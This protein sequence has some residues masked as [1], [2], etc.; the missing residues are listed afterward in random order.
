MKPLIFSLYYYL[1]A[2]KMMLCLRS[3]F[4]IS[5]VMAKMYTIPEMLHHGIEIGSGF[6]TVWKRM[7]APPTPQFEIVSNLNV[8]ELVAI[9][10][11]HSRCRS[12][13]SPPSLDLI[14]FVARSRRRRRSI[15]LP[16]LLDLAAAVDPRCCLNLVVGGADDSVASFADDFLDSVPGAFTVLRVEI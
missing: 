11:S 10:R 1:C 2:I 6:T 3:W 5:W 7:K 9:A 4:H 12:I 16:S 15:S 13:S 14:A 8:R